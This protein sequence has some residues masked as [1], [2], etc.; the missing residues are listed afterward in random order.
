MPL[1]LE[2]VYTEDSMRITLRQ[3]GFTLLE[4]LVVISIIGILIALG[5]ASYTTAQKKGRDA[6]R[7]ADIRA[8]QN[9]LEQYNS[10]N[11][12]YPGTGATVGDCSAAGMA[13]VLP[14]GFPV[15]PKTGANYVRR[16]SSTAY[17][18]CAQLDQSGTG[19][20]SSAPANGVTTCSFGS[21]NY[22]CAMNLQ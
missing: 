17:C 6:R 15:D 11:G 10:L 20:A 7:Q 1:L 12:Q 2:N 14:A 8:L 4:L 19:N 3:A 13:E 5:T 21:G 18:I 22:Y 9:A 16:C